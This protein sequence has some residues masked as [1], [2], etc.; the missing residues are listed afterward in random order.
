MLLYAQKT[1][2][3][4]RFFRFPLRHR[5]T[6]ALM[7]LAIYQFGQGG[8]IYAKAITAQWMIKDAWQHTLETGQQTP[9]WSWADTWPVAKLSINGSELYVLSGASGRN[10]AFGP[11]H[12]SQT[13]LPGAPGN[14]AIAG[15]RDTHFRILKEVKNGDQLL[16]ESLKG[17]FRYQVTDARIVHE[18]QVE[19]LN[20]QGQ[21]QMTLITC[22]PFDGLQ[23]DTEFRYVVKGISIDRI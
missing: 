21:N 3:L 16:L 6:S 7:L 19:L 4:K 18:D 13:A 20:N 5:W 1:T 9:P 23:S 14:V 22:Y 17:Q 12:L 11:T 15:H 10:L 8:Y 2:S